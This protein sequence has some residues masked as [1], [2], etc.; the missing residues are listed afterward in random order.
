MKLGGGKYLTFLL[1][2]E[3]Y[4]IAI[5]SVKEILAMLP[6]TKVPKT[7]NY[8]KG[9]IN[10]R[11]K[12]ISIMDLRLKLELEEKEYNDRTCIIVVEI[13]VDETSKK[14]IGV[15]V[16]L[17][18]EVI[19]INEADIQDVEKE[20]IRI[21]GDFVRGVAKL[22]EKVVVLLDIEKVFDIEEEAD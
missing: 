15:A 4:G 16:D 8:V 17:V 19:D 18:S 20:D 5:S 10:L 13:V 9:V 11:G 12:V 22:K 3:N 14:Q 7:P 1:K 21:R 2:N 6:I